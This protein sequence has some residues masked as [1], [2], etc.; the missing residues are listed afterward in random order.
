MGIIRILDFLDYLLKQSMYFIIK[1]EF[2]DKEASYF[3]PYQEDYD[4]TF[5]K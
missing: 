5:G 3:N 4:N 1:K 2:G